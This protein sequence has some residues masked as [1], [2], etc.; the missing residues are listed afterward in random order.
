MTTQKQS[1]TNKTH[2][3]KSIPDVEKLNTLNKAQ[4][5]AWNKGLVKMDMDIPYDLYVKIEALAKD[6]GISTSQALSIILTEQV[7]IW[8]EQEE[9]IRKVIADAIEEEYQ[10]IAVPLELQIKHLEEFNKILLELYPDIKS[11]LQKKAHN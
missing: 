1:D 8:Q 10:R 11:K 5:Q 3:K 2:K 9:R 6:A 4:H 7:K